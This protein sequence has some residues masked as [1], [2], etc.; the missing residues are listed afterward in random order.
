MVTVPSECPTAVTA[1]RLVRRS[2]GLATIP[3]PWL[4]TLFENIRRGDFMALPL[5]LLFATSYQAYSALPPQQWIIMRNFRFVLLIMHPRVRRR[6]PGIT[7]ISGFLCYGLRVSTATQRP[8]MSF[9]ICFINRPEYTSKSCMVTRI[10]RKKFYTSWE[11][12]RV[13]DLAEGYRYSPTTDRGLELYQRFSWFVIH[14]D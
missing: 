5:K 13:V 9:D 2:T 1:S 12:E 7:E 8:N 6:Y 4:V 11:T 14:P 3:K 10:Q